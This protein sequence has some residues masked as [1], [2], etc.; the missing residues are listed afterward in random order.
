GGAALDHH[1]GLLGA[2]DD[3]VEVA[4]LQVGDGGVGDELALAAADAD[5]DDRAVPG[6]VGDVE[7]GAG[8]GEGEDVGLVLLV[9]RE[10]GRDDLRVLLEAVGE[11]RAEGPIHDPAGEDLLVALAGLALEE[12]AG[13]L[14]GRVRLLDELAGEGEEV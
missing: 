8:A 1:D 13:D 3:D 12:A 6:D 2:G 4:V 9:A 10:D 14:A 7:R 5:A 11:Q